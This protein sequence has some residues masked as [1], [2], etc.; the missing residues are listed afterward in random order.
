MIVFLLEG[1]RRLEVASRSLAAWVVGGGGVTRRLAIKKNTFINNN[2][3]ET[4]GERQRQR[5]C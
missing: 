1:Q 4:Q 5:R 3:H 2:R